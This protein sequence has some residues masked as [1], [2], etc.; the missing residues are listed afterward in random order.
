MAEWFL[1]YFQIMF[2]FLFV[3]QKSCIQ[4]KQIQDL[5]NMSELFLFIFLFICGFVV[6][7]EKSSLWTFLFLY[8]CFN[9]EYKCIFWSSFK[10]CMLE[11][12]KL[13]DLYKNVFQY[14]NIYFLSNTTQKE[15]CYLLK[16]LKE[17]YL[18][19]VIIFQF[20]STHVMF[21]NKLIKKK[22][23]QIRY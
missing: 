8:R 20:L 5:S 9:I 3:H 13:Y 7:A 22:P 15:Y 1:I 4:Q 12:K 11:S 21:S 10:S 17:L 19:L 16:L 6:A 2:I 18:L 23:T 14:I